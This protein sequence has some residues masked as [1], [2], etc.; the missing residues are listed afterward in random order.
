[1]FSQVDIEAILKPFYPKPV[2]SDTIETLVR[3]AIEELKIKQAHALLNQHLAEQALHS[4]Q[5]LTL[6]LQALKQVRTK[7][8]PL[9]WEL[10]RNLSGSM[11]G[12]TPS[13]EP[14]TRYAFAGC[15]S[16]S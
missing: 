4:E 2:S 5:Q 8:L 14:H 11:A 6:A 10:R 16:G 13:N 15:P 9:G 7:T 3:E 12:F 1:M